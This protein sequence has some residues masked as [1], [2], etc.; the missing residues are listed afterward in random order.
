MRKVIVFT[1]AIMLV[2]TGVVSL[3]SAADPV[4]ANQAKKGS[5]LVFP[6]VEV[7]TFRD[8]IIEINNDWTSGTTVKCYWTNNEQKSFNFSFRITRNQPVYFSAKTGRGSETIFS[9]DEGGVRPFVGDE[10][11]GFLTCWASNAALNKAQQFDQLYGKATIVDFTPPSIQTFGETEFL[12]IQS[13]AWEYNAFAFQVAP[14]ANGE[15]VKLRAQV[16]ENVSDIVGK[17]ELS[18]QPEAFTACQDYLVGDL[19]AEGARMIIN[20]QPVTSLGTGITLWSCNQHLEQGGAVTPFAVQ[21]IGFD[22]NEN[23]YTGWA[24]D[25]NCWIDHT[26]V[27]HVALP[28][29]IFPGT[30]GNV[31]VVENSDQPNTLSTIRDSVK[32]TYRFRSAGGSFQTTK[33]R[34]RFQ[35]EQPMIGLQWTRFFNLFPEDVEAA[36]PATIQVFEVGS[37]LTG[38]GT[39]AGTIFWDIQPKVQNR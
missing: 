18:G 30:D 28:V 21:A 37:Q 34:I 35:S 11:G 25:G 23:A 19:V 36:L 4:A 10:T 22:E 14:K 6:K 27:D 5:L 29:L 20:E 8:T 9:D 1:L 24:I 7:S 3:A 39:A 38:A 26:L 2:L 16:G 17:F 13:L 31:I 32:P 15:K 33:G 12:L